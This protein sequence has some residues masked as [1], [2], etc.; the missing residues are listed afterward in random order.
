MNVSRLSRVLVLILVIAPGVSGADVRISNLEN[1]TVPTKYDGTQFAVKEVQA[2]IIE[3][4]AARGWSASLE[5]EGMISASILVRGKHLAQIAI[6]FDSSTFSLLYVS[7]ENLDY[8]PDR[9]TIHRNYNKWVLKL[10]RTINQKFSAGL[11][12]SQVSALE[13][14]TAAGSQRDDVYGK[15]LQLGELR[16]KGIISEEEFEAEKRKLMENQ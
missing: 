13:A 12:A 7:S 6:P 10:S 2:A 5:S 11:A 16:D 1:L 15:L 8:D 9:N 4:C 3:G 14:K